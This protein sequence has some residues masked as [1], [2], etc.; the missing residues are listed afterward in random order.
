MKVWKLHFLI[1]KALTLASS[2]LFGWTGGTACDVRSRTAA[3]VGRG[4]CL[5]GRV[6][7]VWRCGRCV[8]V[9][10][11]IAKRTRKNRHEQKDK[12]FKC[13]FVL[14]FL[15]RVLVLEIRFDIFFLGLM[16]RVHA[17][18]LRRYYFLLHA[19]RLSC[20]APQWHLPPPSCF[21]LGECQ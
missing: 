10:E 6:V 12:N 19:R 13:F 16:L 9:E 14:V 11:R 4:S 21:V 3:V 2:S 17:H 5:M 7:C 8:E 18:V 1:V 15:K 20:T